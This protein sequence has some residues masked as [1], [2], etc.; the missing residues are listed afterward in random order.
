[1]KR[2][3]LVLS[4]VFTSVLPGFA[5]E[6]NLS[7]LSGWANQKNTDFLNPALVGSGHELKVFEVLYLTT[8]T[9]VFR[10]DSV[11]VLDDLHFSPDPAINTNSTSEILIDPTVYNNSD[12]QWRRKERFGD[13]INQIL[14]S[15]VTVSATERRSPK[16][17]NRK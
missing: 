11:I 17:R 8:D 15:Q 16:S 9:I 12:H 14:H 10:L 2:A 13:W 7:N 3:F 4:I 6:Q 5:Q 1:M